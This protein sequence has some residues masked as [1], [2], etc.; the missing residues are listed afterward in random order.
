MKLMNEWKFISLKHVYTFI[1]EKNVKKMSMIMFMLDREHFYKCLDL[2]FAQNRDLL[3]LIYLGAT[4]HGL[5]ASF[6][7]LLKSR[8]TV[9]FN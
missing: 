7:L 6:I 4:L 5:V 3:C 1:N 2:F 8:F 9:L